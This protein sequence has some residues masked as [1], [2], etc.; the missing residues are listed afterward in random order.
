MNKNE[1]KNNL[2]QFTGTQYYHKLTIYPLLATDGVKYFADKAKAYW[3]INDI[4]AVMLYRLKEQPFVVVKAISKNKQANVIYEDG[5]YNKLHSEF[6]EFTDLFEGEWKFF[7]T[8]NVIM[9]PSEY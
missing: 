4:S 1:F 2:E 6:Y 5:N 9:L 3:L 8:D 7:I